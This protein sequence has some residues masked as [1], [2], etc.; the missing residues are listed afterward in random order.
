[1][2]LSEAK[3]QRQLEWTVTKVVEQSSVGAF[4]TFRKHYTANSTCEKFTMFSL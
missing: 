3:R 1:M 4:T 2:F